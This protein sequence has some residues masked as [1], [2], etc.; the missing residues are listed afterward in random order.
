MYPFVEK[1]KATFNELDADCLD[2]LSEIYADDVHF[3]DPVREICGLNVLRDYYA[4]LYQDVLS[5]RFEYQPGMED[6]TQAV[7]P[8]VMHVRHGTFRRGQEITLS[9]LSHIHFADRVHRHR[10]YFDM[11]EFIYERVPVLGAI[12]RRIKARL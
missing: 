1:F 7:I 6:A 8:W 4:N 12:I 11:G 10:D 5:C 9:G 2:R 3:Q